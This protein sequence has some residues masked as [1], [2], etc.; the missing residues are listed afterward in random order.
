MPFSELLEMAGGMW[1]GR[2]L[3]AVI[4]GGSSV[5]VVPGEIMLETNM[6]YDSLRAAGS[7][8]G[9]GAVV[10]MDETTCMVRCCGVSPGFISRNHAASAPRAARGPA[11][12]TACCR[13]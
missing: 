13:A 6:D 3:K 11:G 10:V 12:C 5:Q 1:Q 4:P 9:S 2:Q 7:S 8:I